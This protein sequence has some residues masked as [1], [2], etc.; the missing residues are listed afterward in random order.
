MNVI[1]YHI[2]K[3]STVKAFQLKLA[4]FWTTCYHLG[5]PDNIQTNSPLSG[6]DKHGQFSMACRLWWKVCFEYVLGPW[7]HSYLW[8]QL[9]GEGAGCPLQGL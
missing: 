3:K 7:P 4:T 5:W 1:F 9:E 6:H 8:M 2:K